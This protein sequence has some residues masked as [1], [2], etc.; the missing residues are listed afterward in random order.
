M[1]NMWTIYYHICKITNKLYIGI[2]SL[3]VSRR[4]RNNGEG[5]LLK[6]KDGEFNQPK[7]AN[8]ILKYGW[9]N[10]EHYIYASGL[11]KQEAENMEAILIKAFDTIKNGYNIRE[12]GNASCLSQASK[13]KISKKNTGRKFTEQ[14]KQNCS[15]S[16]L[17]KKRGKYKEGTG[18]N[19]SKAKCHKTLIIDLNITFDSVHDA[20]VFLGVKDKSLYDSLSRRNGRCKGHIVV[21]LN[22]KAKA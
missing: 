12:G 4:W 19:I 14:Q 22:E 21:L 15:K 9:D 5:Y 3:D 17:G 16:R 1:K 11:T 20:A 10:F 2:T 8:A 7:F 13:D 6:N 18:R